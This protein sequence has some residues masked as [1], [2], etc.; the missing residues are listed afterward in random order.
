MLRHNI[1]KERIAE[2]ITDSMRALLLE[3][4][5]YNVQVFEFIGGEHT[6]KN[7]MITAVKRANAR[8]KEE[9]EEL[10]V[11]LQ[12]LAELHGIKRQKL[13]DLMDESIFQGANDTD[14]KQSRK[15]AFR[16]RMPSL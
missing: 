16:R 8:S 2:S 11:R 3:I 12:S 6:A 15:K 9:K 7:I 13:A 14:G 1:Y 5:D 10:R 4:C